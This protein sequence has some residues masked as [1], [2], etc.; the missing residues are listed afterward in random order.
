MFQLTGGY[1]FD[2]RENSAFDEGAEVREAAREIRA[3]GI[4]S[5]AISCIYRRY[6]RTWRGALRISCVRRFRMSH[7]PPLPL[8][9]GLASSS[10]RT[11]QSS[12]PVCW[13]SDAPIMRS[14]DD[15]L[16]ALGIRAPCYIAQN[17]GTVASS[18]YASDFPVLTFGSGPTNSMRGAAFLTGVQDAIVIDVGGTTTDIGALVHGF[19]RE[20]SRG[21][22]DG[23][24]RT[25]FRMPDILRWA[26]EADHASNCQR[27]DTRQP[28]VLNRSA[29]DCCR[30]P[31]CSVV[32]RLQPATLRSRPAWL[33][34]EIAVW[35]LTCRRVL[36]H[37]FSIE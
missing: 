11:P 14:M 36:L 33:I 23:G 24:V 2:G 6:E 20:S 10:A 7:S 21:R 27:M 35:C 16:P 8:L 17:D 25:N 9:A 32:K 37:R 34:L 1:E 18:G 28:W 22:R 12:T 29:F 26:W 30:N 3:S 19:P 15:A 5:V 13:E 31:S 4:G